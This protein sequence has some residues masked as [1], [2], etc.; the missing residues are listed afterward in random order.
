M[1]DDRIAP[2]RLGREID[3]RNGHAA[4]TELQHGVGVPGAVFY[5]AKK[6][7]AS[8]F[9]W[10]NWGMLAVFLGGDENN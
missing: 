10:K 6:G 5:P 7:D 9:F 3:A 8:E 1:F 4:E 2:G